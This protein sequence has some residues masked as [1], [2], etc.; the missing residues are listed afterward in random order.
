MLLPNRT[1]QV[2]DVDLRA[3]EAVVRRGK[4]GKGRRVHI[5]PTTGAAVDRYLRARRSHRLAETSALWLGANNQTFGYFALRDVIR[6]RGEQAGITGLHPHRLRHSWASR[7]LERGGSEGGLM[8]AAGWTQRERIPVFAIERGLEE[9][10]RR[11]DSRVDSMFARGWVEE[12]ALLLD[13]GMERNRTALQAVGYREIIEHLRGGPSLAETIRLVK[14]RT[15]R[16]AR[17]QRTWLRHQHFAI[18]VPVQPEED[19]EATG[20]RILDGWRQREAGNAVGTARTET[21]A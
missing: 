6:R 7:W 11:I 21:V 12:T 19:S 18:R 14:Q 20:R 5:G 1:L 16:V 17:R 8:S 15:W 9:L 2:P 3:G 13:R 4:G 10:R